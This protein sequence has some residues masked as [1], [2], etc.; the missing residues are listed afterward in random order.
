SSTMLGNPRRLNNIR[1][2]HGSIGFAESTTW[3]NENTLRWRKLIDKKHNLDVL[4]G[5]TLQ[6][7]TRNNYG[8]SSQL[9]PNEE[10]G[11]SG[12]DEGVPYSSTASISD[13]TLASF[14]GRINYNYNRK[15]LFTVSFRADGSSK[16]APENR[17]SYFPSGAFAWRMDRESFIRDIPWISESKLRV[18][19]GYT[20]NNRVGDFSYLS[21][22][23]LPVAY[24]YSYNNAT[25]ERGG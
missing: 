20:G 12:L 3:L 24:S 14:L 1:G 17:W 2:Q 16:F 21:A 23:T 13:H 19:F 5:F 6:G 8:Y 18:S 9:V 15:Y 10:L 25:P 22:I 11:M 4:G 7:A